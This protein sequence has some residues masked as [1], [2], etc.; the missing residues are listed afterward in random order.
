MLIVG[1]VLTI[2][3]GKVSSESSL[4]NGYRNEVRV[5]KNLSDVDVHPSV[6]LSSRR[7]RWMGR[8]AENTSIWGLAH[9]IME[10][11]G[12]GHN[13]METHYMSVNDWFLNFTWYNQSLINQLKEL[14]LSLG[15]FSLCTIHPTAPCSLLHSSPSCMNDWIR[16]NTQWVSSYEKKKNSKRNHIKPIIGFKILRV[17]GATS[18]EH[19]RLFWAVNQHNY[20][21]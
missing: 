15:N 5:Q 1:Q 21:I 9:I 6:R 11:E 16:K 19:P 7:D 13:K 4:T 10:W 18:A 8:Q 12:R 2:H 20:L 3:D 17:L 14:V